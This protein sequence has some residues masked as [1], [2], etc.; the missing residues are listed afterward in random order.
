LAQFVIVSNR[1]AIPD[2]NAKQG[3]GG[4]EVAVNAAFKHRTG[5][6]FGWS[7]KVTTP[8]KIATRKIVHNDINY[9]TLACF[10]RGRG[11]QRAPMISPQGLAFPLGR[12]AA[13]S[14]EPAPRHRDLDLAEAAGQRSRAAAMPVAENAPAL[15]MPTPFGRRP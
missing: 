2:K 3:A 12:L 15:C 6:W 13:A 10:A 8:T 5:I 4:L 9:I 7:G 1:V 14:F 11:R